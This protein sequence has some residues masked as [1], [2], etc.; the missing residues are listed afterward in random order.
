MIGRHNDQKILLNSFQ[1]LLKIYMFLR[2]I[3]GYTLE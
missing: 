1:T 2:L 3:D